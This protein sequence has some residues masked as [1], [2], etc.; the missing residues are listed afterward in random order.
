ML[1]AAD[2]IELGRV[3]S[4][5]AYLGDQATAVGKNLVRRRTDFN[6]RSVFLPVIRN[7]LP[8]L[9]DTFDFANP[10]ATTGARATTNVPT[11]G[12]FMLND[13]SVMKAAEATARRIVRESASQSTEAQVD[14]IFELIVN[15]GLTHDERHAM[16]TFFGQTVSR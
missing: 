3:E 13:A 1:C 11:Q 9:F 8:G 6:F 2:L 5:V 12:L 16:I 4:T 10:Q 14:R 7:D 15:S